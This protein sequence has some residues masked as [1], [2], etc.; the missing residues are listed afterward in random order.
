MKAKNYVNLQRKS[1]E[2]LE[3]KKISQTV[4]HKIVFR[5]AKSSH[6]FN[7]DGYFIAVKTTCYINSRQTFAFFLFAKHA[8]ILPLMFHLYFAMLTHSSVLPSP[9]L[10]SHLIDCALP[11]TCIM[12]SII[13]YSRH[14]SH[15]R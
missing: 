6:P 15:S 14:Q 7:L 1:T 8:T 9:Q 4:G 3:E 10:D 5:G 12:Y 11:H 13:F 2:K